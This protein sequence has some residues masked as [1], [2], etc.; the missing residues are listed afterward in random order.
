M[1][2]IWCNQHAIKQLAVP[3]QNDVNRGLSIS[4]YCWQFAR[5]A[6]VE[7]I[8][9]A[10]NGVRAVGFLLF[11]GPLCQLEVVVMTAWKTSSWQVISI[12]LVLESLL[13]DECSLEDRRHKVFT[14]LP[15]AYVHHTSLS[16]TSFSLILSVLSGP[17]TNQLLHSPLPRVPCIPVV[18][19]ISLYIQK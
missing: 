12:H 16:Q 7:L 17:L 14:S 18:H 3:F 10:E 2:W 9:L 6:A 4:L 1:E 5:S 11:M 19:I 13:Y 15:H 8:S